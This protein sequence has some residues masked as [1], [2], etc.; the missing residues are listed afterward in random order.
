MAS[1]KRGEEKAQEEGKSQKKESLLEG[2]LVLVEKIF[3]S[4]KAML[5]AYEARLRPN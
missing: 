4:F 2:G 1:K 5:D 3:E